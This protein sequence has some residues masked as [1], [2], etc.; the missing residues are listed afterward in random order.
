MYNCLV[1]TEYD[2]YK[3]REYYIDTLA[4]ITKLNQ[5]AERFKRVNTTI[6]IQLN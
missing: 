3:K 4:A 5:V 6:S 1:E 2:K